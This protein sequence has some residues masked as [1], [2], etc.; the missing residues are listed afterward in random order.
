MDVEIIESKRSSPEFEARKR[1]SKM[2]LGRST[3]TDD[4]N[5]TNEEEEGDDADDNTTDDDDDSDD[6]DSDDGMVVVPTPTPDEVE[7]KYTY[8]HDFRGRSMLII[9]HWD[10]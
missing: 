6:D 2:I 5:T 7:L 10:P 1:S 8:P 3:G 9:Y 4:D